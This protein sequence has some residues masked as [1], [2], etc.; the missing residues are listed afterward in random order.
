MSDRRTALSKN[1]AIQDLIP[2][3][4]C[5]GCGPDNP[6]GLQIKSYWD[7]TES[8]CNYLPRPEQ[9]AGPT[10]FLYGGTIAS[11]IDCHSVCTAIANHY[12]QDGRK[13]GAGEPI[14]AVTGE[15]NVRYIAPT[16]IDATVTLRATI[17]ESAGKKTVIQCRVF[18]GDTLTA[19]GRVVAI[20]VPPSWRA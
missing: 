13:M 20:R 12:V 9:C 19:E 2:E 5:Y 4:H 16:P 1:S 7:G 6:H 11:L 14:W 15:L 8:V 3:N 10:Q 18:S 17:A